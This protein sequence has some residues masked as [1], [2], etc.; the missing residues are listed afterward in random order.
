MPFQSIKRANIIIQNET[1]FNLEIEFGKL[2]HWMKSVDFDQIKDQ[3][4]QGLCFLGC[5]FFSN[6]IG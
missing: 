2:G 1:K 3:S 4:D 6:R 5:L